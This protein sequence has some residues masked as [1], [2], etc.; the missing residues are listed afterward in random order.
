[1][2]ARKLSRAPPYTH[3]QMSIDE[4][5]VVLAKLEFVNPGGSSKDRIAKSMIEVCAR[6]WV[7]LGAYTRV[8]DWSGLSGLDCAFRFTLMRVFAPRP[9]LPSFPPLFHT[10]TNTQ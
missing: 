7:G 8:E 6:A 2:H 10:H 5:T 4:S 1:M 9:S 3:A